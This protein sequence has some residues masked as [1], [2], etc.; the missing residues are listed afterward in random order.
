M[1]FQISLISGHSE[2]SSPDQPQFGRPLTGRHHFNSTV[3]R[4]ILPHLVERPS[5][6]TS[7]PWRPL[8]FSQQFQTTQVKRPFFACF[9]VAHKML[10]K[11]NPKRTK[12]GEAGAQNFF[13]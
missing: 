2:T 10:G 13:V 7:V 6:Q 5:A 4:Q 3:R 1:F 8:G 11:V 12:Y 9:K